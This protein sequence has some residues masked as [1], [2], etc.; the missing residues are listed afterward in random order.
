VI[1]PELKGTEAA[2]RQYSV[3]LA[4]CPPGVCAHYMTIVKLNLDRSAVVLAGAWNQAIFSPTWVSR[5]LF[6]DTTVEVQLLLASPKV[7]FQFVTHDVKLLV[8]EGQIHVVPQDPGA[9]ALAR[10]EL[11]ASDVLSHLQVT[12][13]T[14]IGVNF[15]FDIEPDSDALGR[16]LWFHDA[17]ALA[18]LGA[19]SETTTLARRLRVNGNIV[20][21]V[22]FRSNQE[23]RL[24]FN[25]HWDVNSAT[26][27]I[28]YLAGAVGR[29]HELSRNMARELYGL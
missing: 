3:G 10:M 9:A 12:P 27:A 25:H 24:D 6:P 5:N 23:L 26:E 8:A 18:G 2:E 4:C 11:T 1:P 28:G 19:A 29:A 15:A 20:N 16:L 21:L 14:A 22:V 7:L 13:L 17:T